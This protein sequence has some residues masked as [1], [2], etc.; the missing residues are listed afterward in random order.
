MTPNPAVT[1]QQRRKERTILFACI[2]DLLLFC[3]LFV[4]III[5]G[6]LTLISEFLR[7]SLMLGIEIYTGWLLWSVHRNRLNSFQFGLGKLEEF[8]WLLIGVGFLISGLWIA[9]QVT[10]ALLGE[11]HHPTP[12]GLALA[13]SINAFNVLINFLTWQGM[14]D[15]R[16][17]GDSEIFAA[18]FRARTIKL[19]T[20]L[21][22]QFSLTIAALSHDAY[23]AMVMDSAGAAL[24]MGLMLWRGT[25]MLKSSLPTL[26]DAPV[27]RQLNDRVV[28]AVHSA[29]PKHLALEHV[30]TRRA[31]QFPHV[32]ITLRA[33]EH[34]SAEQLK[35][36]FRSI[37]TAV[38]AAAGHMD[39]TIRLD[40]SAE[41]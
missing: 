29:L 14:R 8:V 9:T 38:R 4:I 28:D 1:A 37:R 17:E 25:L 40:D 19:L 11:L 18:Q 31:G 26:L 15:A 27:S 10:A 5:S 33:A 6:S 41:A 3:V 20:S 16:E 21:I 2:A 30:R 7:G 39:L 36:H 35:A 32:E 22:L 12:L 23:I 24:V 34:L 13:A